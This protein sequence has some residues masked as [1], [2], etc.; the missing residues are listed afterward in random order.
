MKD[1]EEEEKEEEDSMCESR[2]L[3]REAGSSRS[4]LR[5]WD[6]IFENNSLEK[7]TYIMRF[8]SRIYYITII[9]SGMRMFQQR[10]LGEIIVHR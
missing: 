10:S 9:S 5:S 4:H 7:M 6:S 8:K 3:G 1:V 2:E